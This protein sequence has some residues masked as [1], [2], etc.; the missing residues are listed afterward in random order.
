MNKI[1]GKQGE[2]H[3][4]IRNSEIF[5]SGAILAQSYGKTPENTVNRVLAM[6]NYGELQREGS[7]CLWKELKMY[8]REG[9]VNL[10]KIKK[11]C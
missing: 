2:K 6:M 8:R 7:K 3:Y 10:W 9:P 4:F 5:S 11:M 1:I